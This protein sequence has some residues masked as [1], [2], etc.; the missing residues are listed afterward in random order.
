MRGPAWLVGPFCFCG[1]FPGVR[2]VGRFVGAAR[3]GA[4]PASA[5]APSGWS[6][7]WH[8]CPAVLAARWGLRTRC[9][10]CGRSAQTTQ[11]SQMTKRAGARPP[12]HSAPRH[13]RG[14]RAD[15]GFA[16][17]AP[18][19]S[20]G[21]CVR[22][23]HQHLRRLGLGWPKVHARTFTE[24]KAHADQGLADGPFGFR[25]FRPTLPVSTGWAICS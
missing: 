15:A 23:W 13:P 1:F 19:S 18:L 14:A 24:G 6:C 5:R 3:G 11:A 12:C 21:E 20:F 4:A 9:A 17:C 25:R 10:P 8:D 16:V 22:V 7:L 2:G